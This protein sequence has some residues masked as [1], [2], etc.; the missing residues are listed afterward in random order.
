[1]AV[2]LL[3]RAFPQ[4]VY[5]WGSVD[6][7]SA[8]MQIN[9]A[10]ESWVAACNGNP[11]NTL[12]QLTIHKKPT[13]G[14]NT[15][16][17]GPTGD[18][19]GVSR[20]RRGW[21]IQANN[22]ATK[23]LV[24]YFVAAR[25]AEQFE[26]QDRTEFFITNIE[27]WANISSVAQGYG[28]ISNPVTGYTASSG[29][30]FNYINRSTS[31]QF[32]VAY[33]SDP[34]QEF[35]TIGIKGSATNFAYSLCWILY[36]DNTNNWGSNLINNNGNT[37]TGCMWLEN[38]LYGNIW[39]IGNGTTS[40]TRLTSVTVTTGNNLNGVSNGANSPNPYRQIANPNVFM[41]DVG[42]T[43]FDFGGELI[44]NSRKFYGVH[45]HWLVVEK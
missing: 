44:V 45:S 21:V 2:T 3:Y 4:A 31:A 19:E 40:G 36:K 29:T 43:R 37:Q 11:G 18:N 38:A 12:K 41:T 35:F 20:N 39:W 42:N 32:I 14:T 5:D 9:A 26:N 1:M 24:I 33:S 10:L 30:S 6:P 27:N 22:T 23:G 7:S 13:D 8:S 16:T 15:G 17:V 28:V 34:G 25:F